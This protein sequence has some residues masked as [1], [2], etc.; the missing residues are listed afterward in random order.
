MN[1]TQRRLTLIKGRGFGAVDPGILQDHCLASVL[2]NAW[3]V[4]ALEEIFFEFQIKHVMQ[5]CVDRD[6]PEERLLVNVRQ[7]TTTEHK[8][9]ASAT[10]AGSH[11]RR[12]MK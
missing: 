2:H 6:A 3:E 10:E 4:S 11:A 7:Q 9:C 5:T 12:V 8:E 1:R